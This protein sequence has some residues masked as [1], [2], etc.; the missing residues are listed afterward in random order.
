MLRASHLLRALLLLAGAAAPLGL[1]AGEFNSKLDIGDQAP[2]WKNLPGVDGKKHSL[3]ELEK[4]KLVV[5]V[6]TCNSCDVATSYEDRII[7][8]AKKHKDDVAVVAI[9]VSKKPA[10]ALPHMQERAKERKFPFPY[11]YDETQELGRA[12]GANFTP[13]FFLL[14]GERKVVYMGGM[15]DSTYPDKVKQHYLE[16]A[17]AAVLKGE[18]PATAETAPRGCRIRHPRTANLRPK[19]R[20]AVL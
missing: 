13:E 1:L 7:Q 14:D 15:D 11:L 6:F 16:D 2:I 19:P 12:Y 8:F 18:A 3:A 4:A 5:V 10:D 17:V 20:H 9:N